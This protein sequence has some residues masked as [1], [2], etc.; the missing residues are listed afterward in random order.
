MTKNDKLLAPNMFSVLIFKHIFSDLPRDYDARSIHV[1]IFM[2]SK[3]EGR[4]KS[5][6]P[7]EEAG[8]AEL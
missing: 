5:S 6:E 2:Q 8:A 1:K 7:D 3:Y 4:L